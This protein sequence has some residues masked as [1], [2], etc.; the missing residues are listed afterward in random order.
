MPQARRKPAAKPAEKDNLTSEEVS[1]ALA[2][3]AAE[4]ASEPEQ[5]APSEDAPTVEEVRARRKQAFA[6]GTAEK[7]PVFED[8]QGYTLDDAEEEDDPYAGLSRE[9][10]IAKLKGAEGRAVYEEVVR[11][12]TLM[13]NPDGRCAFYLNG[14][15]NGT[16][17]KKEPED[18][19]LRQCQR[20]MA[21]TTGEQELRIVHWGNKILPDNLPAEEQLTVRAR[22]NLTDLLR[23]L[24]RKP[25]P[26][27]Q[28]SY[29]SGPGPV[30]SL[31]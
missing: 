14:R 17:D 30:Q 15:V 23:P 24:P 27:V 26:G 16:W 25:A 8:E 2:E 20:K 4:Q 5:K 3:V 21:T 10:L 31:G 13:Y 7:P 6:D 29:G 28:T 1:D 12:A 18:A 22:P 9:E 11:E 19:V